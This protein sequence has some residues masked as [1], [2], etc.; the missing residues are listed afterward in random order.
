MILKIQRES[1]LFK[2]RAAKD[3]CQNWN[4]EGSFQWAVSSGQLAV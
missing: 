1:M 2:I 4:P 3:N